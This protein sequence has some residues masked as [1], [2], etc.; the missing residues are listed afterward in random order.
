MNVYELDERC[1]WLER[2]CL[3]SPDDDS[4][5]AQLESA[6][7]DLRQ[8]VENIGYLVKN[9]EAIIKAK[10]EA[11]ADMKASRERLEREV[12]RLKALAIFAL[13]ASGER[14]VD[15]I[16]IQAFIRQNP[17][18]VK[19]ED[20]GKIPD[21]YKRSETIVQTVIDR[22]LLD[23][24]LLDGLSIEGARVVATQSIIYK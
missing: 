21:Q 11:E 3:E 13:T 19:I 1:R 22:E 7:G 20:E 23:R 14:R 17:P 16:R 18:R 15:G 2:A 4:L 10:K 9:R 8:K 5:R 6:E 12:E 24:D